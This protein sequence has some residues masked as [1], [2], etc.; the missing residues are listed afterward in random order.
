MSACKILFLSFGLAMSLGVAADAA[1][2]NG[3]IYRGSP[4]TGNKVP[5]A[6]AIAGAQVY[7]RPRN[8]SNWSAPVTTDYYGR[9]TFTNLAPGSYEARAFM[10]S[11]RLWDQIV[12]VPST[13]PRIVVRDVTVVYFLKSGDPS[14]VEGVCANLAFPYEIGK[15][16]N[17]W[18]TNILWFG[19]SV[20]IPDVK[21]LAVGL[22]KAGITLRAI[23]RF[24]DG[25]GIKA[26]EIQVGASP[27]HLTGPVLSLASINAATDWPRARP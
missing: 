12:T 8:G 25:S 26:K 15:A 22:V 21:A 2:L 6:T 5:V 1:S 18:A 11:I 16:Q 14:T 13:L 9:F 17:N 4:S 3:A 20:A 27:Q 23:R 19:D 24:T 7:V 10:G